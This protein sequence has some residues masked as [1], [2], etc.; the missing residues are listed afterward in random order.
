[1]DLPFTTAQFFAVIVDYNRAIWPAQW[2]LVALAGAAVMAAFADR[3]WSGRGVLAVLAGFWVW[4]GAVYHLTFFASIN[5]AARVFGIAFIIEAGLLS[6]ATRRPSFSFRPR[7][8]ARSIGGGILIGYALVG[9]PIVAMLSGE[10][11]PAIP[12]FGLPCPTTIFTL[13]MLLWM[14]PRVPSWVIAIPLLWV[15]VGSSAAARFGVVADYGLLVA[16]LATLVLLITRLSS[17][18]LLLSSRD[19]SSENTDGSV[20][21][22]RPRP[23]QSSD[24]AHRPRRSP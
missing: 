14:G 8:D 16:G 12:T 9:Y 24:H 18:G 1:M 3:P 7:D 5:P 4:M 13:G 21:A 23:A 2:L 10:R 17:Q 19:A 20:R 6:L 22:I 11:Y 15:I